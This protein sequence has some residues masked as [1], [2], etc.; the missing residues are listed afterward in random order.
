LI[1]RADDPQPLFKL[2]SETFELP[3]AWPMRIYPSFTSGGVT[4]GNLYLE[5][6][7]VESESSSNNSPDARYVAMAFETDALDESVRELDR[8]G[9]PRGPVVPNVEVVADGTMRKLYANSI[10]GKLLGRSFWIDYMIFMGRLPGASAMANP[11]AGGALVRWGIKKVMNG[12]LVFLVEYAYENFKDLP[13]WS[14]FKNH[15]E[16]RAA[17]KAELDARDGG[18]LGCLSVKE[19]VASVKDFEDVQTRW[20]KFLG[21]SAE[22]APGVWEIADG[23][24]VR[25]VSS[26]ENGIKALVLKVSS[27]KRAETFLS[28]KGMLGALADGQLGIAPEKIYG[29]DVRLVE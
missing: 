13:H 21:A 15:E 28:E 16:K 17:D 26:P 20:R 5:I 11:G 9:I 18:A 4:L 23:P 7:S 6:I 29:L 8:R 22:V 19:I 12:K 10:L 24:Q 14:E 1:I 27:L 25:L 3:I 2:L